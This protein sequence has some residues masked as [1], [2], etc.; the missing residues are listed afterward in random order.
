M[1]FDIRGGWKKWA[2]VT[3]ISA[4]DFGHL[5]QGSN[6]PDDYL[7]PYYA[8]R[9]D[10]TD[11]VISQDDPLLQIPTAYTQINMMQKLRFKPNTKWDIQYGFHFSKTSSFGRYDRH[12]RM[13]EGL[14]RYAEWF[15]GPQ[16]WMMNLLSIEH[17]SFNS[18]YDQFT[19]RLAYQNFEESRISRSLNSFERII[20]NEFVDA[21]S[22]NL[23]FIKKTG[24][25]NTLYYGAEYV[26]NNVVSEGILTN[27]STGISELSASRYP[28]A[29]WQSAGIY[30]NDLFK[31]SDKFFIQSGARYTHFLLDANFDTSFYPLPF[32]EANLT[33]GALTGS[34]GAIYRPSGNWAFSMNLA[35]AFRSPNVDDIGKIFDSE[36]G[37]VVI[38]NPDLKAEYAYSIDFGVAKVIN[39]TL[40]V[41]FTAYYTILENA[42]VRRNYTLNGL[43]SIQYE[44]EL[45]QV[46]A[47]QN[48]AQADVYG[49][50]AGINLK[51]PYGF[52]LSSDIN[53]QK[54]EEE[55]DDGTISPSRHAAPLFGNTKLHFKTSKLHLE[56][57]ANYQAEK[58]HE[59]LPISEQ[60]KTE[61]Y[62]LDNNG[63][64]YSPGWYTLNFKGLY[65]LTEYWTITAG[66]E[67]LTDQRYRPYSSGLSGPGRNFFLSLILD[68]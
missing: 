47:V 5:K 37:A 59:D 64:T 24:K 14:P 43:D 66:I 18:I 35:S 65:S 55:Q 30:V 36:P 9:Q 20:Q 4:F 63:N 29:V 16:K 67:N 8:Q 31:L 23:D 45:S 48:A 39:H 19:F 62:A 46:Q 6:G 44:G 2:F 11:I 22:F 17:T 50:Q 60:N 53:F 56:L 26:H 10:T 7:K 38:A 51:L 1:H 27:I 68:F 21:L 52:S 57:Y 13:R 25:R 49:F 28:Q 15:Y 34:L 33:N 41:D 61:I 12:N 42:L 32:T 58:S 54:G 40:K 3:S